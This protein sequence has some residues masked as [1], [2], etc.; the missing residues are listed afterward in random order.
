D[1]GDSWQ[2]AW[3]APLGVFL[4]GVFTDPSDPQAVFVGTNVGGYASADAGATWTAGDLRMDVF[5][6]AAEQ[7]PRH[8][9]MA[10][11]RNGDP[12]HPEANLQVSSDRGR[13]WRP[14]GGPQRDP[15]QFLLADP[16]A[17]GAFVTL[18]GYGDLYRTTDAGVHWTSLGS[19]PRSSGLGALFDLAL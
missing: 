19:V 18:G 10:R 6:V 5:A 4:N 17:P 3:V 8:R 12:R 13:T 16:T 9:L 2:P 7:G 15:I 1:G 14:R 11:A